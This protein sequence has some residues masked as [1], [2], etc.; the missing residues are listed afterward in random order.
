MSRRGFGEGEST[1]HLVSSASMGVF[2]DNTLANFK[3]LFSEESILE[4]DWRV[5]LSEVNFPAF[6]Y[7]VVDTE[8]RVYKK[9]RN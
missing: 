5:A 9:K 3:N 2:T 6:I 4:G 7:N 8:V 1:V